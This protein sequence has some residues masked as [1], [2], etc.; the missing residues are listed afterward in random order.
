MYVTVETVLTAGSLLVAITA[1]VTLFWKLFTWINHQ[2]E[3]DN[4]IN[5]MQQDH[6]KEIQNLKDGFEDKI[7]DLND[8]ISDLKTRHYTDT[9]MIHEE[10]TL[11]VYGLLACLKGLAEQGCD[12]PVTEAISKIEKHINQKA[13]SVR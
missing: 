8:K 4:L 11:V 10:Q 5:E 1:F 6:E 9:N 2:K 3:Q 7:S 13:H 12:G